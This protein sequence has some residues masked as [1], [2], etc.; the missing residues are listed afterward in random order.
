MENQQDANVCKNQTIPSSARHPL[1][2]IAKAEKCFKEKIHAKTIELGTHSNMKQKL[3]LE[4]QQLNVS[5]NLLKNFKDE[6]D[7]ELLK[8]SSQFSTLSSKNIG[9]KRMGE[10]DIKPFID[11]MKKQYNGDEVGIRAIE[12]HSLWEDN[13]KNPNWHPFKIIASD[14][15][16]KQVINEEDEKLVELKKSIGKAAYDAVV[17]ALTEIEE[18]NPAVR[19]PI[20]ELWNYK[21]KRR[22]T[23]QEGIQFLLNKQSIERKVGKWKRGTDLERAVDVDVGK[24]QKA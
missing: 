9:V 23:L 4:L 16:M 10:L 15:L 19:Y 7:E 8:K 14:G 5:L 21:E 11:D 6:E 22:A 18:Y 1:G 17:V 20:L 2:W 13:I 3:E 24:K 12:L